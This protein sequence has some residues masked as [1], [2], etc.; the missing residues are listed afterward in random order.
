MAF[1]KY[2]LTLYIMY[3]S[4]WQKVLKAGINPSTHG[5]IMVTPIILYAVVVGN[6]SSVSG[7]IEKRM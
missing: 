7:V 5:N 4:L 6:V 1:D 2:Y 3:I